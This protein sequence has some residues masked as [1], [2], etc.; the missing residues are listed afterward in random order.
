MS[1]PRI[2]LF[3]WDAA[4][5]GAAT[6]DSD[7]LLARA[8]QRT[9][10]HSLVLPCN[11]AR[12][13]AGWLRYAVFDIAMLHSSLLDRQSP[14]VL[15]R[16]L[17]P[18][19]WLRQHPC[20]KAALVLDDPLA[21]FTLDEWLYHLD[22]TDVYTC[23]AAQHIPLLYPLLS[24][25]ARFRPAWLLLLAQLAEERESAFLPLSQR[26]VELLCPFF[27]PPYWSGRQG[28]HWRQLL[29][30]ACQ[31]AQELG[32]HCQRCSLEGS[33]WLE[34]L[35]R[36]R[37]VL[38]PPC[39]SAVLDER[40]QWRA[41]LQWW[42]QQQPNLSYEVLMERLPAD[43]DRHSFWYLGMPHLAALKMHTP[44]ILIEGEYETA[45]LQAGRHF[46]LLR[47]DLGN[48]KELLQQLRNLPALENLAA[49][50][51]AITALPAALWD[52]LPQTPA[53]AVS[54]T[55]SSFLP[56]RLAC[57]YQAGY[58]RY[59]NSMLARGLRL[60]RR[61]FGRLRRLTSARNQA[62][63]WHLLLVCLGQRMG[64][65]LFFHWLRTPAWRRQAAISRLLKDLLLLR[66]ACRLAVRRRSWSLRWE[67]EQG[68][69]LLTA[70]PLSPESQS[71]S[72]R[73]LL[74]QVEQGRVRRLAWDH[75]SLGESVRFRC[76]GLARWYY[77]G[78]E[79]Y[80]TFPALC[81]LFEQEPAWLR[82]VL[83][84]LFPK[85]IPC[86]LR[87]STRQQAA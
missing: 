81:C 32:W 11:L 77:I 61:G 33:A 1:K 51:Q 46:L 40:G 2:V 55:G 26:P 56:F 27:D 24:Q 39:G 52:R 17:G 37:A 79:G 68:T 28:L 43:W 53:S 78:A 13:R 15:P 73:C 25:Q 38:L 30:R 66:A 21:A 74:A 71:L 3:Y 12:Q 60:M 22:V 70:A 10:P 48:L 72:W 41:R 84:A 6:A 16:R 34:E 54:P 58:K 47:Q 8:L 87:S 19:T 14:D 7:F 57:L 29:E 45:P 9:R 5:D 75:Q 76:G 82:F 62:L 50:A 67:P 35:C 31:H 64:R 69:L 59:Q 44:L 63:L 42:L 4:A 86:Y 80:Y 20:H 85:A 18:L 83:R 65:V 23:A 36:A 49:Q